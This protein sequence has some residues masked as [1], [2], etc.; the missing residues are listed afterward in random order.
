VVRCGRSVAG[1]RSSRRL[2]KSS[3]A[4]HSSSTWRPAAESLVRPL[5][6]RSCPTA[7]ASLP[8]RC[9]SGSM[10]PTS[11]T[12]RTPRQSESSQWRTPRRKRSCA[13][14]RRCTMTAL[15]RRRARLAHSLGRPAP[16]R[17]SL[18]SDACG[19][20]GSRP[21]RLCRLLRGPG[22]GRSRRAPQAGLAGVRRPCAMGQGSRRPG[23]PAR[24]A[25][26]NHRHDLQRSR[27]VLRGEGLSHG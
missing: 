25:A 12:R 5:S 20:L 23:R 22:R 15:L 24:R 8:R 4:A 13:R 16:H 9:A 10:S 2:S 17:Q 11:S 18:Q 1:I 19:I 26:T 27:C 14:E 7:R 3:A 21:A 6:S